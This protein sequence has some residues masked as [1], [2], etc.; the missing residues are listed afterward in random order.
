MK[1]FIKYWHFVSGLFAWDVTAAGGVSSQARDLEAAA[2]QGDQAAAG[3]LRLARRRRGRRR[4]VR[5]ARRRARGRSSLWSPGKH[6]QGIH[7]ILE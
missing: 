3:Q 2:Q 6:K 7:E 5:V 4:H 1:L